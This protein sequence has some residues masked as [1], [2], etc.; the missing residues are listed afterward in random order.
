MIP[1]EIG[2]TYK[3][4]TLAPIVL[5]ATLDRAR[6]SSIMDYRSAMIIDNVESK[7]RTV[8]PYLLAN[9]VPDRPENYT[10][11]LFEL[12]G[13][14]RTI[15]ALEWIN[16]DSIELITTSLLTITIPDLADSDL[17]IIR[18]LLMKAGYINPVLTLS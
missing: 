17:I 2:K 8:Y 14:I 9:G 15:L 1:F 4:D 6:V 18:R 11:V 10:Y 5:G 12:S 16:L 3:F 13:S 7:H